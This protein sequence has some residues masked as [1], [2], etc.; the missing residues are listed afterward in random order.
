[1]ARILSLAAVGALLLVAL[2]YGVVL[3]GFGLFG[4]GYPPGNT[5]AIAPNKP[6]KEIAAT[7]IDPDAIA[8]TPLAPKTDRAD[9]AEKQKTIDLEPGAESGP[10][11]GPEPMRAARDV[12]PPNVLR[13]ATSTYK[14]PRLEPAVAEEEEQDPV[15]RYHRVVVRDARTLEAGDVIIRFAGIAAIAADRTCTDTAGTEWPCGRIAAGALRMLIRH[16]A[17][18]CTVVSQAEDEITATC[19]AGLEDING[20]LVEQ[21]WAEVSAGAD[22]AE[23]ADA[24]RAEKRG[25]YLAEWKPKGQ[26]GSGA[27]S[28]LTTFTAPTLPQ[29][30]FSGTPSV[31]VPQ[32]PVEGSPDQGAGLVDTVQ[33]NE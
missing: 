18:D 27:T 3:N 7:P 13:R 12:T 5:T 29:D 21:G 10:K 19:S 16:R 23:E 14:D 30:P 1:M 6:P 22:Y 9:R 26:G 32:G 17:I 33:G 28:S 25:I 11:S 2:L 15:R 20:W 24:A 8:K 4:P 31:A